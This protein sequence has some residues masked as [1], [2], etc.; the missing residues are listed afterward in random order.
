MMLALPGLW[1]LAMK[2][3]VRCRVSSSSS[4]GLLWFLVW[5]KLT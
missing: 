1:A 5:P 2:F 3:C 4:S